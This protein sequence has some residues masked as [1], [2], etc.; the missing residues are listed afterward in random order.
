MVPQSL[1][2]V[3]KCRF[4]WP[5]HSLDVKNWC[6]TCSICAS[7]KT[8]TLCTTTDNQSWFS[9]ASHCRGYH[10]STGNKNSYILVVGDYFTRWMEA[11]AIHDQEAAT[12]AQ[13]L[14]NNVFYRFGIPE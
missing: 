10:G 12:V 13:K 5:S 1:R 9:I 14:V 7:H 8:A 4:Y 2:E 6:Q 11:Y 3:L